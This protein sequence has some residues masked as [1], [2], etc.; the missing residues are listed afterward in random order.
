MSDICSARFKYRHYRQNHI[1]RDRFKNRVTQIDPM[2]LA[3]AKLFETNNVYMAKPSH[4]KQ[5][6]QRKGNAVV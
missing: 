1:A 6:Q 5:T 2:V 4:R 3:D